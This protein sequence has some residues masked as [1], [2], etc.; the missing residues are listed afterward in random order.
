MTRKKDRK[1]SVPTL[2]TLLQLNFARHL[3]EV[4]ERTAESCAA[5]TTFTSID[6]V[7]LARIAASGAP[8][9]SILLLVLGLQWYQILPMAGFMIDYSN[10]VGTP[11]ASIGD[12]YLIQKLNMPAANHD[13]T[14]NI[15][16][17][18][19]E[20][21]LSTL[22][23][24]MFWALGHVRPSYNPVIYPEPFANGTVAVLGKANIV[25]VFAEIQLE[26]V[27]V[28]VQLS[29]IAASA[30]LVVSIVLMAVA[31]PLLQGSE[32]DKDLPVDGTGILHTLWLYR[33]QPDLQQKLEQVEHPTDENLRAAGTV[34]VRLIGDNLHVEKTLESI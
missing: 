5:V 14:N 19:F 15:T 32:F 23:A 21:T 24:S 6:A 25:E 26:R 33:D 2:E 12:V 31:L 7:P 3:D 18:G 17:H 9:T 20:S 11:F 4:A 1:S 16:L 22:V 34:R 29:I 8:S 28:V 27:T 10:F 13:D 30:G